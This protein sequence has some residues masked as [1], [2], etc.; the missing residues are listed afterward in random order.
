[1]H[2]YYL[3]NDQFSA[4][5]F[6]GAALMGVFWLALIGLPI[7]AVVRLT[8]HQQRPT[9]AVA[10]VTP[11]A[12]ETA[13]EILDRRLAVGEITHEEYANTRKLLDTQNFNEGA[14]Q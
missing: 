9:T 1:M 7:W 10:A 3:Y 4:Y 8:R 13:R 11:R 12:G 2:G 14:G 6:I 5:H